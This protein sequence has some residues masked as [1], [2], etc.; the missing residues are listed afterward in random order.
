M[1]AL[2]NISDT[3]AIGMFEVRDGLIHTY[4]FERWAD[5]G[6]QRVVVKRRDNEVELTFLSGNMYCVSQ[7]MTPEN[8][9]AIG[10]QLIAAAGFKQ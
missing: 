3:D 10:E 7:Y 4:S 9:R 2:T 8:A 6:N 5:L 1:D